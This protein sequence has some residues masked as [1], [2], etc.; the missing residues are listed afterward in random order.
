[1]RG[2]YKTLGLSLHPLKIANLKAKVTIYL[3]TRPFCDIITK[4][5]REDG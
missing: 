3:P 2:V 5:R 4:T 1:L